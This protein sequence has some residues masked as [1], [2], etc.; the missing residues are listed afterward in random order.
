MT[1]DLAHGDLLLMA[2]V[3]Q[4]AYLHAV[5]KTARAVGER[6]NLTLRLVIP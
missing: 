2:G 1:I 5:P 3:T 4:H 6:I